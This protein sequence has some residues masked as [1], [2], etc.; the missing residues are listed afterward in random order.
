MAQDRYRTVRALRA[1]VNRIEAML[2]QVS[3][4]P[5]HLTDFVHFVSWMTP[6]EYIAVMHRCMDR[7]FDQWSRRG[8]KPEEIR[9]DAEE[10]HA[11]AFNTADDADGSDK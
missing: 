1:D 3:G 9:I 6:E 7:R 5:T 4:I 10:K 2:K 8:A 11:T